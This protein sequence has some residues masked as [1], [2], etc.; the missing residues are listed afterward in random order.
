MSFKQ[1]DVIEFSD[2]TKV[3]VVEAIEYD[4]E[5]Y[6]FVNEI[7]EDGTGV[8]NKYKIMYVNYLNG[9]LKKVTDRD[10]L[11]VLLPQFEYKLKLQLKE[12]Q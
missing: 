11:E 12:E 5:E 9:S 1:N 8:L 7:N 4:D 6:V 3:L 2:G 10:L